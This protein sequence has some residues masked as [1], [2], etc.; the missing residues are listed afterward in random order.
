MATSLPITVESQCAAMS[1]SMGLHV[2]GIDL[3]LCP[4]GEYV[5]FEVNS[6]PTYRDLEQQSGLRLTAALAQLLMGL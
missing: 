2:S 1:A 5:C 6:A 4:D 3:R